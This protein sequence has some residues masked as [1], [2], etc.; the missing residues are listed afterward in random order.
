M[1]SALPP[2]FPDRETALHERSFRTQAMFLTGHDL[3]SRSPRACCHD[4]AVKAGGNPGGRAFEPTHVD[5]AGSP[6]WQLPPAVPS[7]YTAG[8]RASTRT[9]CRPRR[10]VRL[11]VWSMGGHRLTL[12]RPRAR[13][14]SSSL[15]RACRRVF[16]LLVFCQSSDTARSGS[17]CRTV[18]APKLMFC[19]PASC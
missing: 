2:G 9:S 4:D 8:I 15:W 1:F 18:F 13:A 5:P 10:D 12:S 16:P 11:F 3:I 6:R 17:G 7:Q 19:A 14:L